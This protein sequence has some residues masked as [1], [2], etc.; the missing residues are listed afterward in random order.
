MDTPQKESTSANATLNEGDSVRTL[1]PDL[2]KQTT[3]QPTETS[4]P[5]KEL[6]P[7]TDLSRGIVGWDGQDDPNNPQNFP[8]NKKWALLSLI[9]V[10]TLISPLA[11][12]MFSPAVSYVGAEFRVTDQTILSLSISIY[13][14]GYAFGPILLA[15]LS[16]VYGRRVVIS[17][18]NWFFVVWQIGCALAPNIQTLIICRLFAGIGGSGCLTLGAGVI[19]DLFAREQR[20]MATSVWAMGPLIGPVVGPIAGGFLGEKAGWRWVFWL[21]LI[22]GGIV[23]FGVELLNKETYADVLLR[24]KTEKLAKETGR[25]DLRS[26][27]DTNNKPVSVIETLVLSFKRPILLLFKSPIV[28]LL[29]VYMSFIYGLLY[30]FFTTIPGV[31]TKTYGFSVGLSGLAY[32]GI[33]FGFMGGLAMIAFTSDRMVMAATAK[34]GG[35]FEPE[36]RLPTMTIFACILPISFFWYGWS[37]DKAVF[38]IVPIIGMF[39][40]GVGMMGVYMPLQTYVI[41]CYPKYAASA[42]AT[43]TATRSLVG[44]LLPLAGPKM[45]E[46]LGLG[47]GNSLLGFLALAFIPV[48]LIFIKYGKVIREKWPVDLDGK[49]A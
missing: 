44:A 1:T 32:F 24:W 12:S 37:A 14:L 21:L 45:F 34:N 38:W 7:E 15:P 49:K 16:E 10:M 29:C 31:F 39:P 28:F 5:T 9:S 6:F 30:L 23:S 48:P 40:F 20:G 3:N 4:A 41:D 43:L 13:V 33:G 46:A 36:M 22:V 35:K 47:W 42:N 27:Y 26:A 17:G 11:S 8:A 25:T 19:A 2:E 18:A